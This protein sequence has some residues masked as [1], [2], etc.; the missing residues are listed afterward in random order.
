MNVIMSI[1]AN[2]MLHFQN[3]RTA[4]ND[5]PQTL[6]NF[7]SEKSEFRELAIELK[8]AAIR[9]EGLGYSRKIYAHV[10]NK[11]VSDWKL[12][13]FNWKK[14]IE[15]IYEQ[16]TTIVFDSEYQTKSFE[17]FCNQLTELRPQLEPG[18]EGWEPAMEAGGAA[19]QDMV[20]LANYIDH[21]FESFQIDNDAALVLSHGIS[22]I[23][24]VEDSIGLNLS[25]VIDRWEKIPPIFVPPVVSNSY[26]QTEKSSLYELLNDAIRAFVAGAQAASIA[27]CRAV[28]EMVLQDHYLRNETV[29]DTS[30][31]NL[32]NLAVKKY[33]FLPS[34]KLHG[35]RK[36]ANRILHAYSNNINLDPEDEKRVL[37]AIKDIKHYIERAPTR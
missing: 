10:P 37:S 11:F 36:D 9:V 7:F 32:I 8:R 18:E 33:D 31:T 3:L 25:E 12:Y 28:L 1:Y 34:D 19:I 13:T 24:Y 15:Y 29:R 2:F 22:S 21:D 23:E 27:M 16:H 5:S 30:L 35:L 6:I 14:Q 17:E 26:G 20:F 4:T